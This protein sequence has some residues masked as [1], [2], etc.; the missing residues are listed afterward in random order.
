MTCCRCCLFVCLLAC[1]L[2]CLFVCLFVCLFIFGGGGDGGRGGLLL[3]L[4]ML[5]VLMLLLVLLH[6][7]YCYCYLFLLLFALP[8]LR[9]PCLF[10]AQECQSSLSRGKC[11]WQQPHWRRSSSTDLVAQSSLLILPF[12]CVPKA[13]SRSLSVQELR[14]QARK[15]QAQRE[16]WWEFSVGSCFCGMDLGTNSHEQ[17]R[18]VCSGNCRVLRA[19]VSALFHLS[20]TTMPNPRLSKSPNPHQFG[21]NFPNGSMAGC[22]TLD[23][24]PAFGCQHFYADQLRLASNPFLLWEHPATQPREH[25][26]NDLDFPGRNPCQIP[27]A[28][29]QP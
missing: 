27:S 17:Q 11:S 15:G 14:L 2:A 24:V 21:K 7:C 13:F 28:L 1:L 18:G 4:L 12:P 23:F 25:S 29:A 20:R 6:C 5:L 8:A 3:L 16:L 10:I 9:L 22:S 26:F 19:D